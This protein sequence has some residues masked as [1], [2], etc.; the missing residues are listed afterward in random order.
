[1]DIN[2]QSFLSWHINCCYIRLTFWGVSGKNI[3]LLF[4]HFRTMWVVNLVEYFVRNVEMEVMFQKTRQTSMLLFAPL[5]I[6]LSTFISILLSRLVVRNYFFFTIHYKFSDHKIDSERVPL[7]LSWIRQIF[8]FFVSHDPTP[9]NSWYR[10]VTRHVNTYNVIFLGIT[11]KGGS[12]VMPY[13]A[14]ICLVYNE[15]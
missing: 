4:V 8:F 2:S 11:W 1:M 10:A 15:L 14:S 12:C 6:F 13:F 9:D 5:M 3:I 7:F